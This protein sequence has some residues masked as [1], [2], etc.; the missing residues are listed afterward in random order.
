MV[1][2]KLSNWFDLQTLMEERKICLQLNGVVQVIR[3]T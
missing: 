2:L 3:I 1:L